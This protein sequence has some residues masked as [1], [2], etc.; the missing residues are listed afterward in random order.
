MYLFHHRWRKTTPAG[1]QSAAAVVKAAPVETIRFEDLQILRDVSPLLKL[2]STDVRIIEVLVAT[3]RHGMNDLSARISDGWLA[4]AADVEREALPAAL[5]RLADAKLVNLPQPCTLVMRGR[6]NRK[7]YDLT[8]MMERM[9]E[10]EWLQEA[11]RQEDGEG[12]L[13]ASYIPDS[14]RPLLDKD[15]TP[16]SDA[17]DASPAS[18]DTPAF[19]GS[20]PAA[21]QPQEADATTPQSFPRKTAAP[22]GL[23]R[24]ALSKRLA[25]R[26][27]PR[28][29]RSGRCP[30]PAAASPSIHKRKPAQPPAVAPSPN[31]ADWVMGGL[32]ACQRAIGEALG[33]RMTAPVPAFIPA[34]SPVAVRP[35]GYPGMYDDN[36]WIQW[37]EEKSQTYT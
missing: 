19:L 13:P 18:T 6:S 28:A 24:Q 21:A 7:T 4:S 12:G 15:D 27:T 11:S 35:R 34:R 26:R 22:R 37:R 25:P 2:N 23:L 33:I 31:L 36:Y 5:G 32:Q 9:Q 30:S 3:A 17:A 20:W 1:H 14:F 8:P 16:Q 10:L 29:Q